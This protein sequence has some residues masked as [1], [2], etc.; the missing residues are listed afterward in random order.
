MSTAV[1]L[2]SNSGLTKEEARELGMYILP[3]PFMIDGKEYLDGKDITYDEFLRLQ[4]NGAD[5]VTS[6]PSPED[7][8]DLWTEL[9]KEYDS[10]IHIPMTSGLSGSCD[11]ATMLSNE[12]EFFGK[13]FVVDNKRISITQISA[14]LDAIE[15]LKEG[16]SPEKIKEKLE[17]DAGK[18]GIYLMVSDLKYLKKGGRITPMAAA[19]ASLLK[20]KPVLQIHES[21]IDAY[22]KARTFKQAKQIMLEALKK[23]L[24]ERLD[25]PNAKNSR[26]MIAQ[27]DALD[28]ANEFAAELEPVFGKVDIVNLSLSVATHIGP[29]T[30]A[31]AAARKSSN[32]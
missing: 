4:K 23:D 31:V 19:L 15:M 12:D 2:D 20:I 8:M 21:K 22:G 6:Q 32:N 27:Y 18:S 9:L 30:V 7:V 25:D 10:I 11:T 14:G 29:G 1:V 13:V 5:I 16:M 17:A 24:A 28:F 3:M 26:V